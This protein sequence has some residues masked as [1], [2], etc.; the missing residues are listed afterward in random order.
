M[1][2]LVAFSFSALFGLFGIID[3]QEANSF[4]DVVTLTDTFNVNTLPLSTV[5]LG[6]YP[7]IKAPQYTKF[8]NNV[9]VIDFDANVFVTA[10]SIFEI[11]GKVFRAWIHNDR[12]S[13]FEVS[14]RYINKELE[15]QI[16]KLGGVKVYEGSLAGERLKTYN[17]LVSYSGADGSFIPANNTKI[18]TYAIRHESGNIY[19]CLEKTSLQ[20][21]SFQIVQEA[22]EK[23]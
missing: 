20:T 18:V 3:H 19:I 1:N 11:E 14:N 4:N 15:A 6:V 13:D 22:P 2:Y 9:K 10:D 5:D 21:S 12:T 16:L 7:Y 17:N 8:I 23:K